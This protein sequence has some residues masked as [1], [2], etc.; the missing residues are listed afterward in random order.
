MVVSVVTDST[1]DIPK[2]TVQELGITVVPLSVHFGEELYHD[3]VDIFADEFF[4]KLQN[5]PSLPTTSQ[6]SGGSFAQVYENLA[7]ETEEIISIHISSKLSGTYSSALLGKETMGAKCHIE[8]ID[9]FLASMGLGVVVIAAAQAARAGATLDQIVESVRND[10]SRTHFFG[11][12][13]TL[14]YLQKGGRIGR[15][16]AFL[17][18]LL[19]IKPLIG[20][21]DGEI[22][23]LERVRSRKR[24]LERLIEFTQ[25]FKSIEALSI[26]HSTTPDDA[27][28][29]IERLASFYP[30]Q[31]IHRARFGPVI[32]TYLGPGALGVAV[33]EG[34]T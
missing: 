13:D 23:G 31:K 8:I 9:S 33:M 5:S 32:G 30:E 19:N 29:L 15:A 34:S 27:K 17:G 24:V 4:H 16:Q 26:V 25:G 7:N 14:E 2:E 10:I 12:V 3:G 21:D 11:A 18:T 28:I 20:I 22:Y 6:P 1:A